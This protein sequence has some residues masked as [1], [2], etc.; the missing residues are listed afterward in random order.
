MPAQVATP[1]SSST[2]PKQNLETHR[3]SCSSPEEPADQTVSPPVN[4]PDE[5]PGDIQPELYSPVEKTHQKTVYTTSGWK[6]Q[7]P[8]RLH[9]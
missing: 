7:A 1:K 4:Q 8:Q 3:A 2:L 6:V 5:A 9:L